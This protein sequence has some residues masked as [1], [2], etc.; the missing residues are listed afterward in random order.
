MK[1]QTSILQAAFLVL[2]AATAAYYIKIG[3]DS[4]GYVVAFGLC[5]LLVVLPCVI[6]FIIT[7]I[8]RRKTVSST[9][10]L[11]YFLLCAMQ[12]F[13]LFGSL[14]IFGVDYYSLTHIALHAAVLAVGVA[15][16]IHARPRTNH[17]INKEDTL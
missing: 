9:L 15:T 3:T 2:C 12:L 17:E 11:A 1:K 8:K 6:A 7:A 13:P 14:A 5:E 4:K 10:L 16:M